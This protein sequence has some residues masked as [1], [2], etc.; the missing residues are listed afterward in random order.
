MKKNAI[1]VKNN[2]RWNLQKFSLT[3]Q[4]NDAINLCV[5]NT[6]HIL[7]INCLLTMLICLSLLGYLLQ[8]AIQVNFGLT[9]VLLWIVLR[10]R[11]N[12]F[13]LLLL[14]TFLLLLKSCFKLA[15]KRTL[16]TSGWACHHVELVLKNIVVRCSYQIKKTKQLNLEFMTYHMYEVEGN[17]RIEDRCS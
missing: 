2:L 7:F 6:K 9:L 16:A 11:Q 8:K 3:N 12:V 17:L 13:K 14:R 15:A 4:N 5:L 10:Q 1:H